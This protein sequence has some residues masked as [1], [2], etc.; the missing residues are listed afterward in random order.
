MK[1]QLYTDGSCDVHGSKVGGYAVVKGPWEQGKSDIEHIIKSGAK[2]DTT[3]NEMELT[4]IREA[5]QWS[6][7]ND[8]P[9]VIKSDSQYAIKSIAEWSQNWRWNEEQQQY[10]KKNGDKVKNSSLIR[11]IKVLIENAPEIAFEYVKGHDT[12]TLNNFADCIANEM[13]KQ[14]EEEGGEETSSS[15]Y[16][17]IHGILHNQLNALH[18]YEID[19][20][21]IMA[22][23]AI[24]VNTVKK[25]K[26]LGFDDIK[27]LGIWK[28][29]STFI[30]NEY[31]EI[32]CKRG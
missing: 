12:D 2:S 23:E 15:N 31:V 22:F 30:K 16:E 27:I 8:T 6:I 7:E 17:E 18:V 3:N 20:S 9:V 25:L 5:V 14:R 1:I 24:D 28:E 26:Q 13:R 11:E 29:H 32:Q 19:D 4:A 21:Y 10:F